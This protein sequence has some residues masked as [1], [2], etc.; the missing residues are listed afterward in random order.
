MF[1]KEKSVLIALFFLIK[2]LKDVFRQGLVSHRIE[3]LLK[4]A[5]VHN[6]KIVFNW[7]ML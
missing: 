5:T 2:M 4:F 3:N 1:N 6:V 7:G